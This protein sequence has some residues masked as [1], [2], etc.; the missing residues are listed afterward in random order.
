[1]NLRCVVR[2]GGGGVCCFF[3]LLQAEDGIRDRLV[4]G[5]QTCALPIL[6]HPWSLPPEIKKYLDLN[7][8]NDR[9]RIYRIVPEKHQR[10]TIDYPGNL[11]KESWVALLSHANAWHRET[12]A[13]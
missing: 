10:Q 5:V 12:A 4:T 13:R 3:F 8:G 11:Q 2:G 6:E 1:M 9:G 7:S